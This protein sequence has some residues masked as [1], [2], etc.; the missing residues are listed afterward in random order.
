MKA[1]FNSRNIC[2]LFCLIFFIICSFFFIDGA[3]YTNRFYTYKSEKVETAID[4]AS[5]DYLF[6]SNQKTVE[7]T[8]LIGEQSKDVNTLQFLINTKNEQQKMSIELK[9]I[10]NQNLIIVP[11]AFY[12]LNINTDSLKNKKD[13]LYLLKKI[14]T[15]INN[16]IVLLNNIKTTTTD[17]DF[18]LFAIQYEKR[19]QNNNETLQ[20]LLL[21]LS[22]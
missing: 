22:K 1:Y 7:L 10:V 4:L 15:E 9:K 13:S 11:E 6:E 17:S 19:I 5:L 3:K 8:K 21:S 12:I 2:L 18:R 20:R 14:Q 16:Q